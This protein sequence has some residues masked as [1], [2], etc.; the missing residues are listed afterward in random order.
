MLVKFL[1]LC[2]F[3]ILN[4][5][6]IEASCFRSC[7][8]NP[9]PVDKPSNGLAINTTF[10]V[11]NEVEV[12]GTIGLVYPTVLAASGPSILDLIVRENRLPSKIVMFDREERVENFWRM[13]IDMMKKYDDKENFLNAFL[14]EL[15]KNDQFYFLPYLKLNKSWNSKILAEKYPKI[16]KKLL[17]KKRHLVANSIKQFVERISSNKSFLSNQRDYLTIRNLAV[18]DNL[19]FLRLDLLQLA[20]AKDTLQKLFQN[21]PIGLL[22]ISNIRE[23]AELNAIDRAIK[24]G[25]DYS[26]ETDYALPLRQSLASLGEN[27]LADHLTKV[28][29]TEIRLQGVLNTNN[30]Y[31][32][33]K[34]DTELTWTVEGLSEAFPTS[35]GFFKAFNYDKKEKE[36]REILFEMQ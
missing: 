13:V 24:T 6:Q 29:S 3:F 21:Q 5:S 20:E 11:T 28:L 34:I 33:Q 17:S 36:R 10:L 8:Y 23:H 2:L 16:Y 27:G 18:A 19:V 1:A 15:V 9:L 30:E 32:K 7:F 22:Y 25:E 12:N 14:E 4:I 35:E 26:E 31:L